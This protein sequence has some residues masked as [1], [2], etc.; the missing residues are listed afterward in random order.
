MGRP[1]TDLQEL[2]PKPK[3]LKPTQTAT[4]NNF[5]KTEFKLPIDTNFLDEIE[6]SDCFPMLNTSI[7]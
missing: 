4:K 1:D 5:Q 3:H 2:N 6:K 7:Y